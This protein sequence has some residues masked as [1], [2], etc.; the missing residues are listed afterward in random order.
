MGGGT[1]GPEGTFGCGTAFEG[2]D[3]FVKIYIDMT[4]KYDVG[5]KCWL[6]D[7][8]KVSLVEEKIEGIIITNDGRV[9]YRAGER[10]LPELLAFATRAEALS[11][12][13]AVFKK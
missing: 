8:E 4:T 5:Q 6:F 11:Y 10:L 7:A 12:Y 13:Q 9:L 3:G 1:V 2:E